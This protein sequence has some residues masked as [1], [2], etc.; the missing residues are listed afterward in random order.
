MSTN[1]DTERDFERPRPVDIGAIEREL[2]RMWHEVSSDPAHP[3]ARARVLNLV[4]LVDAARIN[5]ACDSAAE[6]AVDH[7][8]RTIIVGMDTGKKKSSLSAEVS[9]RCHIPFGRRQQVC[10]EQVV[11]TAEGEAT[12][13]FHGVVTP[14]LTSDLPTFLWWMAP[15]WPQGHAFERL[16]AECNRLV[17][18]SGGFLNSLDEFGRLYS[19]IRDYNQSEPVERSV[20][21]LNWT[22][23]T[24]WRLALAGLYDVPQYR[25]ALRELKTVSIHYLKSASLPI[26]DKESVGV[27]LTVSGPVL[28]AG[29]LASRLGW[30]GARKENSNLVVY[31]APHK[32]GIEVRLN[33]VDWDAS[34]PGCQA[35]FIQ[36][37]ELE[38]GGNNGS[39]FTIEIGPDFIETRAAVSESQ[40]VSRRVGYNPRTD[41]ELVSEEVD[42]LTRDTVYEGAVVAAVDLSAVLI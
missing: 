34:D 17:V 13:N 30:T 18:D 14:L 28:I 25:E 41:V 12:H 37:I 27:E 7:P 29:W 23:L 26:A 21:D 42:I 6:V 22:R 9:A 24:P 40:E 15:G 31:S 39:K 20:A 5:A 33:A 1:M 16:A 8:A 10:S 38:C 2:R 35:C 32:A 3:V 36:R 11:I 4:V 19:F